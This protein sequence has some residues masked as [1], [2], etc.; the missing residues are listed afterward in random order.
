MFYESAH[1]VRE[2]SMRLP[3]THTLYFPYISLSYIS[4]PL[5]IS[6]STFLYLSPSLSLLSINL[7]G[8]SNGRF[9][10]C[11]FGNIARADTIPLKAHIFNFSR[12]ISFKPFI[13]CSYFVQIYNFYFAGSVKFVYSSGSRIRILISKP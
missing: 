12:V 1:P 4:L 11:Y 2:C 10:P 7:F 5:Y 9:R 3:F 8:V 6:P 13:T